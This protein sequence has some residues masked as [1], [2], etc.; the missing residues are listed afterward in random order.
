MKV[1]EMRRIAMGAVRS[2]LRANGKD[3]R[4]ATNAEIDDTLDFIAR[5]DPKLIAA[6]WYNAATPNQWKL[7]R[8]D[9][10]KWRKSERRQLEAMKRATNGD[11]LKGR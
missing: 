10:A 6:Q 11:M 5:T 8:G 9:W 2:Q 4:L 1:D 3:P 7:W